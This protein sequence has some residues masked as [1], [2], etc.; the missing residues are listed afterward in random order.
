MK[1]LVLVLVLIT[2]FDIGY[3]VHRPPVE[4]KTVTTQVTPP[5]KP[6]ILGLWQAV[7]VARVQ[8]GVQPLVLSPSL[9]QSASDKCTDMVTKN[10]WGHDAP[11]GTTPW[12]SIKK[13]SQY[14][15]AAENLAYGFPTSQSVIDGWLKSPGHR[16]NMLNPVYAD[17]GFAVCS[18]PNYAGRGP[19]T[20]IV[21]HLTK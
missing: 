1:K 11:D 14:Q 4:V 12:V 21:E 15:S 10:Y 17:E 16:E 8:A 7:N 9:N 5:P 18:S 19:Q 20:I 3:L 2:V 13:Y 6:D